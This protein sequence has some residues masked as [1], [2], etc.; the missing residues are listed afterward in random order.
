MTTTHITDLDRRQAQR[1]KQSQRERQAAAA[2]A[3]VSQAVADKPATAGEH[4]Q[5]AARKGDR[6]ATFNAFMDLIAPRLTLAERAVW[7]VMF[8]HARNGVVQ[9]SERQLSTAANIDK[10]T[11]GRALRR[12]VELRLVWPVFKSTNKGS[13]SR[14]GLHPHPDSC[15]A[16]V[17]A[18]QERRQREA[19]ERRQGN[20]GDRRGRRRNGNPTG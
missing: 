9:A 2:S 19:G 20:G 18:E 1:V 14:Y 5:P 11:A 13:A 8:R 6:W 15:L 7:L 17:M 4:Q 12:L 10:V 3:G 16:G